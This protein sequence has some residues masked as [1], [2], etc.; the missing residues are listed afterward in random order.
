GRSRGRSPTCRR[1]PARTLR[2]SP[3]GGR[4]S[5]PCVFVY[6][7]A[8]LQRE[9]AQQLRGAIPERI[10]ARPEV[11][12]GVHDARVR[13]EEL[14]DR[15]GELCVQVGGYVDLRQTRLD[16][17]LDRLVGNAR[18][19]VQDERYRQRA[20]DLGDEVEIEA[21]GALGHRVGGTDRHGEGVYAGVGD[22]LGRFT[23]VGAHSGGVGAVLA[24]DLPEFRLDIHARGVGGSHDPSRFPDVVGVVEFRAVVH[25]GGEAEFDRREGEV[26]ILRVVQV[27]SDLGRGFP[28]DGEGGRGDRGE[29]SVELHAV[30]RDL[31]DHGQV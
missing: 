30:L 4:G 7:R 21:R 15:G 20:V 12:A 16:T 11:F 25:H 6:S 18:G 5:G 8:L 26:G 28:C 27:D 29:R 22:E 1:V 17:R 23:R 10:T 14:V 19:A 3:R 31:Q 24:A 9:Q 13:L 2:V